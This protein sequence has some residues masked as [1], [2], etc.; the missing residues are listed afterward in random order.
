ML[1]SGR[2]IPTFQESPP[3]PSFD[4]AWT[5][6]APLGV[7]FSLQ[8]EDQGLVE[9]DLSSRTHLI[10]ISLCY[11]LG[12]CYSFKSCAQSPS[13]LFLVLFLS[14]V[15]AHNVASTIFWRVNQK[16]ADL[17]ERNA[18]GPRRST[19]LNLPVPWEVVTPQPAQ[20]S[21]SSGAPGGQH[22]STWPGTQFSGGWHASTC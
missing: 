6:L 9:F 4:L 10:L 3:P 16:I 2:I 11:A 12:L 13:L 22:A 20:R 5:V 7:S 1:M 21:A 14:P 8:I 18:W 15:R 19:C 17:W